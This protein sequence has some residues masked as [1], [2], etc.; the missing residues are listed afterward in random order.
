[1]QAFLKHYARERPGVP[2]PSPCWLETT[3]CVPR[4]FL[5]PLLP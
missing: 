4:T 2:P 5:P 3:T 1:V